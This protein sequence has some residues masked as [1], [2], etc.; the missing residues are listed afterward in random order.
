MA[1]VDL[2][3]V[4]NHSGAELL[5]KGVLQVPACLGFLHESTDSLFL[6]PFCGSFLINDEPDFE[7]L[8]GIAVFVL[9]R[10]LPGDD[11]SA[12]GIEA[13]LEHVVGR[14]S[15]DNLAGIRVDYVDP[16][17]VSSVCLR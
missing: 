10:S 15:R 17:P 14:E 4:R 7:I 5:V 9:G 2:H 3:L 13:Q 6:H 8:D 11:V 12:E 16:V 1:L